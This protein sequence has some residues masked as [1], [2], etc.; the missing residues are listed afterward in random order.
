M[1]RVFQCGVETKRR[2]VWIGD[3]SLSHC[4]LLF[5]K[6]RVNDVASQ[7]GVDIENVACRYNSV[8][9]KEGILRHEEF[10]R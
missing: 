6:D 9:T 5:E 7:A 4:A 2:Q 3:S 8:V 10:G 1:R